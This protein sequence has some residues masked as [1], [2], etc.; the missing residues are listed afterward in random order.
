MK[1]RVVKIRIREGR[2]GMWQS[3]LVLGWIPESKQAMRRPTKDLEEVNRSSVMADRMER[4]EHCE[5][6][7]QKQVGMRKRMDKNNQQLNV[8]YLGY[9][10]GQETFDHW[11]NL[12]TDITSFLKNR[13]YQV[14]EH[15]QLS[16]CSQRHNIQNVLFNYMQFIQIAQQFLLVL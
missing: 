3:M 5:S 4:I 1:Y 6:V 12:L 14:T 2:T 11:F 15:F 16:V 10:F 9:V 7:H 8:T 13:E